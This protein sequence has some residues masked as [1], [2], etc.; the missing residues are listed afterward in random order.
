MT[1]ETIMVYPLSGVRKDESY[2]RVYPGDGAI[3]DANCFLRALSILRAKPD[4]YCD[5]LVVIK[6]SDGRWFEAHHHVTTEFNSSKDGVIEHAIKTLKWLINNPT[7]WSF[8]YEGEDLSKKEKELRELLET[9]VTIL[10]VRCGKAVVFTLVAGSQKK[11]FIAVNA[12]DYWD[13][14]GEACRYADKL[15]NEKRCNVTVLDSS[16]LWLYEAEPTR[17]EA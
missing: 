15:A 8:F 7:R 12:G 13:Q 1:I 17:G 3:D 2:P 9:F 5:V 6:L 14:A 16:G 11:E 4:S 10:N